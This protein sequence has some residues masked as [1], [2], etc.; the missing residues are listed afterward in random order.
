M[1]AAK[2]CVRVAIIREN[3]RTAHAAGLQIA[4]GVEQDTVVLHYPLPIVVSN[5]V[6]EDVVY[7]LVKTWW[8]NVEELH[9]VGKQLAIYNRD[10]FAYP[11]FAVP[12]HNGAVKFYREADVWTDEMEA[13]QKKI[14]KDLNL[15]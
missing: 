8:E 12:F 4:E 15:D 13:Q 11:L 9:A 3:P 5:E 10:T 14:I 6:S 1:H 7:T 2:Q